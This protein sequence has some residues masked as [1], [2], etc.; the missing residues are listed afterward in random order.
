M[1]NYEFLDTL[2]IYGKLF[3]LSVQDMNTF[4]SVCRPYRAAIAGEM[5]HNLP[6][7][8]LTRTYQQVTM[9]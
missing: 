5:L 8:S 7:E 2:Q 4:A 6:L 3:L 9:N 1:Q